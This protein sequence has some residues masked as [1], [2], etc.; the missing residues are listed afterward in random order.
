M[1]ERHEDEAVSGS[2]AEHRLAAD[3]VTYF[4][5]DLGFARIDVGPANEALGF[6]DRIVGA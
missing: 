4:D 3:C 2:G 5:D 6:L 1:A